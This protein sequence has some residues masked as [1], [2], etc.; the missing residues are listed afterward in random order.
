M[1]FSYN[2]NEI[3]FNGEKNKKYILL[4]VFINIY[5]NNY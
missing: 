5:L 2:N 4:N 3:N 1:K